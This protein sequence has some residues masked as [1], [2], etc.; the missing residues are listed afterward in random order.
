MER[1]AVTS[2]ALTSVGYDAHTRVLEIEFRNAR[3]YRY[4]DVPH[5]VFQFLLRTPEKGRYVNRVIASRYRF[6]PVGEEPVEQDLAEPD[7]V[8][9]LEAS[10]KRSRR[11]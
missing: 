9:A 3:V 10:L 6:E 1:R 4:H 2:S 7:L 8:L 5:D 11:D